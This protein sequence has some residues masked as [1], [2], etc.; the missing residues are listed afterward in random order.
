MRRRLKQGPC[1]RRC[2]DQQGQ[3]SWNWY[4]WSFVNAKVM[5]LVHILGLIRCL[6]ASTSGRDDVPSLGIVSIFMNRERVMHDMT[7]RN[8]RIA[9]DIKSVVA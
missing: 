7:E 4:N 3:G 5:V 1:C 2:D 8:D 6:I 9:D